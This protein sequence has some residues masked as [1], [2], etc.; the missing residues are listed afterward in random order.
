MFLRKG[1]LADEHDVEDTADTPQVDALG[2]EL[3]S[4]YQVRSSIDWSSTGRKHPVK[5]ARFAIFDIAMCS[6]SFC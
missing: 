5:L 3:V 6:V 2:V 1:S 4:S